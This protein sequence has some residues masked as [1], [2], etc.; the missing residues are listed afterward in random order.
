MVKAK[1]NSIRPKVANFIGAF[2]YLFCFLQW[3]WVVI[4]YSGYFESFSNLLLNQIDTESISKP[5][6]PTVTSSISGMPL[7]VM[8]IIIISVMIIFTIYVIFKMPSIILNSSKNIV[9]ETA[10][11]A[12]PIVAKI[13]HKKETKKVHIKLTTRLVIAVKAGLI[14]LAILAMA[15]S[16]FVEKP[17]FNYEIVIIIGLWLAGCSIILFAIQYLIARILRVDVSKLW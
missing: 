15:L 9:H 2:G 6:T 11:T 1:T 14:V 13:A 3:L 16:K 5:I 4:L 8:A 17:V 10:E 12:A 7:T